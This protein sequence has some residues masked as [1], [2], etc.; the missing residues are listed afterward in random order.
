[1][2]VVN[3]GAPVHMPWRHRVGAVV[4]AWYPGQEGGHALAAVLTGDVNPSGRLPTTFP[5][6]LERTPAHGNFPG[7]AG[8][9]TYAEGVFL[10]HRWFDAFDVE[11]EWCFGHGLSYTDFT[12]GDATVA[13][14]DLVAGP[15]PDA[16]PGTDPVAVVEVAVANT[17]GRGGHEVVQVYLAAPAATDARL[18]RPPRTLAGFARVWVP[19]GATGVARLEVDRRAF[20]VWD[21]TPGPGGNGGGWIVPAGTYHLEVAASSRRIVER[22]PVEVADGPVG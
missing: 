16:A 10:G 20:A 4:Q 12:W 8:T 19:A 18:V 5:A 1:V 11:P 14:G 17:G 13:A 9:V 2:V 3:A 6:D 22:L 21:P 7:E 15:V